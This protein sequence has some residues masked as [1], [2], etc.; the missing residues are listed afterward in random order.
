MQPSANAKILEQ[1]NNDTESFDGEEQE[2][3]GED[4]TPCGG[5]PENG[6]DT[7]AEQ[8][9]S[10]GI[11]RT[12]I[13]SLPDSVYE[14]EDDYG[15]WPMHKPYTP[16]I[17]RPAFR[18]PSSVQRMQMMSPVPS[19]RSNRM[20]SRKSVG[21]P[22]SVRSFIARGSSRS[23]RR[24]NE[25]TKQESESKYYPLV[26]LHI[27]VL[28]ITFEWSTQAMQEILPEEVLNSLDMLTFKISET[29]LQRGLL[30]PHPREEYELLE[31]RLLEAL[32]LTDERITKCGHFC[33][34]RDSIDSKSTAV[35]S[36]SGCGSSIEVVEE[37]EQRCKTCCQQLKKQ[38]A[39]TVAS[40]RRWSI[41]VYAANGLMT[42]S[43]WAAAWSDM[44]RVDVEI[45]PWISEEM[46]KSLNIRR[47]EERETRTVQ[48]EDVSERIRAVVEEQLRLLETQTNKY[49]AQ[50]IEQ[51]EC[52]QSSCPSM[53][54]QSFE[55]NI[56]KHARL[57]TDFP[58]IYR[59]AEIPVQVLMKNYLI[60]LA[61]DRRNAAIFFLA[62]LA[63][64]LGL[65]SLSSSGLSSGAGLR[66]QISTIMLD[67]LAIN[68][69]LELDLSNVGVQGDQMVE[70]T[71]AS[72][73]QSS[74]ISVV[75]MEDQKTGTAPMAHDETSKVEWGKELQKQNNDS[76]GS[77]DPGTVCRADNMV[78][79]ITL[80]DK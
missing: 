59:S 4:E 46:V 78:S 29:I 34:K 45:K 16:P 35:D 65:H 7:E 38:K 15:S 51:A 74:V 70:D 49:N 57:P 14:T 26:L 23:N 36:D 80:L 17:M 18:R 41:K 71:A 31:E 6:Q 77:Q 53:P 28:P 37:E 43:A 64:W 52:S 58:P 79:K 1:W 55:G 73:N 66:S 25:E 32:E 69:S 3:G 20:N 12:S 2:Q 19:Q 5:E 8:K 75:N 76:I 63:L 48:Q 30:I 24:I 39:G 27:T 72:P 62:V 67:D 50:Q 68:S 61:Q 13:S 40:G 33:R 44:E 60:L 56:E 47:Q 54:V 42:S 22:Q 9:S 11:A 21:T 10:L